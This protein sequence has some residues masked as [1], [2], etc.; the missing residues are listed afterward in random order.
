M[1]LISL[2]IKIFLII[3][4]IFISKLSANSFQNLS[5]PNSIEFKLNNYEYN[6]YL[7]RGMSAY[8]DSEINGGK[9]NIKKKIQ[10][11]GKWKHYFGR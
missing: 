7:R 10:E 4:F 8:V 2:L 5:I 6:R 3:N 1:R 11:M 9:G